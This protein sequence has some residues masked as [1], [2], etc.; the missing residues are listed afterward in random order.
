M[1]C[2]QEIHSQSSP[3]G[4]DLTHRMINFGAWKEAY[5][6]W[7]FVH[8]WY[9]HRSRRLFLLIGKS[10]RSGSRNCIVSIR[11]TR[12]CI[13]TVNVIFPNNWSRLNRIT[14]NRKLRSIRSMS[15]QPNFCF[16][17]N[18]FLLMRFSTRFPLFRQKKVESTKSITNRISLPA[19]FILPLIFPVIS[20]QLNLSRFILL[21]NFVPG[22]SYFISL[23][24][25][26]WKLMR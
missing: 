11:T 2:K 1:L 12:W 10:T 20:Y 25:L 8:F 22:E 13:V 6:F 24:L 17:S 14:K 5:F 15:N 23:G 16:F 9:K 19:F 26:V 21:E 3:S 7:L 4:F 18:T